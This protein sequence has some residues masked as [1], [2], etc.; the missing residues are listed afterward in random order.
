MNFLENSCKKCIIQN[1]N[2]KDRAFAQIVNQI[3]LKTICFTKKKNILHF[4]L[5]IF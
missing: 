3:K 4:I 2:I 5:N 1:Q